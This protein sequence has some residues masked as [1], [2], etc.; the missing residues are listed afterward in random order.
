MRRC[1][2]TARVGHRP[3]PQHSV[4]AVRSVSRVRRAG[5]AHVASRA[6]VSP[7]RCCA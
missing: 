4:G 2:V 6:C 5:L 7:S 1:S 3:S